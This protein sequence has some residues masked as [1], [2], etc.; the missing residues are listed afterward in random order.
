MK[1]LANENFPRASVALLRARG[2]NVHYVA[3]SAAS[4]A[5]SVVLR[6]ARR[7]RRIVL[8]FDR[9]YGELIY[10]RRQPVPAGVVFLRLDPR[11]PEEP[12]EIVATL[13]ADKR[14]TLTGRFTVVT[15]DAAVRQRSL[16]E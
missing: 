7:E 4:A 16:P 3:E 9:D 14:V 2:W 12:G 15:R 10:R 13:L 11:T 8:T 5:D 1:L 6:M